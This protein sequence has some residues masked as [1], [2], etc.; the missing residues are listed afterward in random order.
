MRLSVIIANY[1]YR[2]FVGAAIASA[3]AI[4]WPDT[5]TIV[6]DDASTDDSRAVIE[7]FGD[8]IAAYFRPK[9]H[10]LG[11]HRFGFEHCTGDVVVLLDADD[12]LEPVIMQEIVRAWRPGLSKIQYRMKLISA[13]GAQLGTAMPQFPPNDDP[14]RLRRVFLRTM[15]YTTPPGSGNAYMRDFVA[16][17]YAMAPPTMR[18][19]DPVLLTLAPLMGDVVTIRRPLARYRIHSANDGAL[20]LLDAVK[21]RNRLQTDVEQERLFLAATTELRL[22][23]PRNPLHH[24]L[25]HLQYRFASHMAEPSAHPFPE[26][27]TPWLLSRFLESAI[28]YPQLRLRERAMLVAWALACALAPRRYR[29][30]L[31]LWRFAPMARPPALRALLNLFG[32]L[33]VGGSSRSRLSGRNL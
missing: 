22:S 8:R 27:T 9:S 1:N 23:V 16:K 11:A 17:A 6:V 33:R 7:G 10:Q 31:L 13:D 32:S 2:D 20:T 3:L 28:G 15:S 26:D 24:S 19:S 21:F 29:P 25:A 30:N 12:L 18:W 5:E 14:A 4:D